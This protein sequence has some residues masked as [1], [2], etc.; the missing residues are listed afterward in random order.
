MD[1]RT[2]FLEKYGN[3]IFFEDHTSIKL[4]C[5]ECGGKSLSCS[6]IHGLVWCFK[7]CYGKGIR[8]IEGE[9]KVDDSLPVN[10]ELHLRVIDKLLEISNLDDSSREYLK[11]RGINNPD[12]YQ[13]K[14]VPLFIGNRLK[15]FFNE[16]ELLSSGFFNKI[17]NK[18][19]EGLAIKPRRIILPYWQGNNVIGLKTRIRPYIEEDKEKRYAYPRGSNISKNLWYRSLPRDLVIITEGEIKAIVGSQFGFS[20]CAVPGIANTGHPNIIAKIKELTAN[21]SKIIVCLDSDENYETK[22]SLQNA[23]YNIAKNFIDKSTILWLPQENNEK[24]DLDSYL[25]KFGAENL[26]ELIEKAWN[27]KEFILEQTSKKILDLKRK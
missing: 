7:C 8:P 4:R 22:F 2:T 13:I 24:V 12:I 6:L 1:I 9:R 14:N 17:D 5:P 3:E 19:I 23:A 21:T 26:T 11:T 10:S 25:V 27:N 16:E 20:C 18:V 15:E